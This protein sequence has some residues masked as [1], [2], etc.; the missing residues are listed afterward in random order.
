MHMY[1]MGKIDT[2]VFEIMRV[3]GQQGGE[4]WDI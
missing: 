1:D 3:K 4:L 2:I